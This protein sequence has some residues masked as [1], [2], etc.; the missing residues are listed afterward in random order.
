MQKV[1][2]NFLIILS[3]SNDIFEIAKFFIDNATDPKFDVVKRIS[4][5]FPNSVLIC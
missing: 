5:K 1:I 2:F 3:N 4:T